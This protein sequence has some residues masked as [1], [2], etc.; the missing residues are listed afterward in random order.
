MADATRSLIG[1]GAGAVSAY[2][3]GGAVISDRSLTSA[4]ARLVA[5]GNEWVDPSWCGAAKKDGTLCE[6]Q[7]VTGKAHC[8][9]HLRGAK[10]GK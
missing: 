9:G 3:R 2:E 4:D 6:A 8:I 5:G 1:S 10:E 7:P